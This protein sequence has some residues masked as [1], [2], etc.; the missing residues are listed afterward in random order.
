M[1]CSPS[2]IEDKMPK[3]IYKTDLNNVDWAEMKTTLCQD[4]FDNGRSPEQLKTSFE[5]SYAVCIAYADNQII[6]TARA[7]SDGVCNAYLIDVWTLS[8]YRH[9][10]IATTTIQNILS[11]LKGQHVYLF[12]DD[13]PELYQKLGFVEQPIGMGKIVGK[14]LGHEK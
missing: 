5:N 2:F 6:S 11:R 9:Q 7:L 1:G 14:W 4:A 3:I 8:A 10:G 12:T 13:V